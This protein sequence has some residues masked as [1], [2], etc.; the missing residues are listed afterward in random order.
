[1][2]KILIISY[3]FPPAVTG[4]SWRH[5]KFAKY[6]P[7]FGI[8]VDILTTHIGNYQNEDFTL[9]NQ[10]NNNVSIYRVKSLLQK[11]TTD[12]LRIKSN[13]GLGDDLKKEK[14]SFKTS[15]LVFIRNNI[16]I[17]DT[18]ILWCI[19]AFPKLLMLIYKHKYSLVIV[20]SPPPSILILG[21]WIKTFSKVKLIIDYRDP[22]TQWF[23]TVT[24]NESKF[25]KNFGNWMEKR[26]IREADRVIC[27]TPSITNYLKNQIQGLEK[28]KFYTIYNGVDPDD[29]INVSA[30]RFKKKTMLYTGLLNEA[31]YSPK[32]F[33]KVLRNIENGSP[34]ILKNFQLIILGPIDP[35]TVN[36][37]EKYNLSGI[38]L[39][40]GSVPHRTVIKYL[41]GADLLLLLLNPGVTDYC[42]ISGKLFEYLYSKKE[43]LALIPEK[44]AAGEI[45]SQYSKAT[46][47]YPNDI[48][49]ITEFL[50]GW[51]SKSVKDKKIKQSDGDLLKKF[52]RKVQASELSEIIY[53]LN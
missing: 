6:L 20:T 34:G 39:L 37:I 32:N 1:M 47:I 43:I 12:Q 3:A 7:E 38:V 18:T 50:K 41:L 16:L 48:V 45:I 44:S 23:S 40:I 2:K 4:G 51:L 25:R 15:L 30:Q 21:K 11:R 29:F 33:F 22:W 42:T 35:T 8:K 52:N 31:F 46:M 49:C 27:T 13:S 28:N 19:K 26:I 9:L 17:P 5:F 53:N 36:L 24:N 14:F 10:L